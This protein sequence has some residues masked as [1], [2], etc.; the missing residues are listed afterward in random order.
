MEYISSAWLLR[1]KTD[2]ENLLNTKNYFFITVFPVTRL[3]SGFIERY[4]KTTFVKVSQDPSPS[5]TRILLAGYR[6]AWPN[7]S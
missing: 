1:K 4:G 2:Q 5:A 3:T 6:Y 7:Y